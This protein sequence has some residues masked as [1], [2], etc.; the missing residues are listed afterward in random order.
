VADGFYDCDERRPDSSGISTLNR[1][2]SLP[3]L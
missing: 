1:A 2:L 3:I